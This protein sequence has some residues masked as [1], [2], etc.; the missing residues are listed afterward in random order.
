[1]PA[2]PMLM[3]VGAIARAGGGVLPEV[4]VDP[5][6]AVVPLPPEPV[7]PEELPEEVV[8]PAV[9]GLLPV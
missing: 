4:L 1:M 6:E 5:P 3:L 8:P 7:V 9:T 2:T